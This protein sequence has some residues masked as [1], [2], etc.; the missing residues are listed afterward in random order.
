MFMK[1]LVKSFFWSVKNGEV[2]NKLKSRGF[3]A[4]SVSAYDFSTLYTT[5]PHILTKEKLIDLIE[6]TFQREGSLYLVC[7]AKTAFFTSE[8]HERYTLCVKP[9]YFFWTI[10]ILDL[11]LNYT[12]KL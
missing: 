10:F 5:S 8:E 11:A 12:D 3:W 7:K 6:I 1:G 4:A 2:L 9:I